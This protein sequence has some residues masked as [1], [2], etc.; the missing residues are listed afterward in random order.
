MADATPSQK[1]TPETRTLTATCHCKRSSLSF[2]VPISALPI[3]THFCHCGI[4]RHVQGVV[5]TVHAPIPEPS[6]KDESTFAK[7]HSSAALE[8]WFCSTC[9]A[10]MV[11]CLEGGKQWLVAAAMV[12]AEE[13]VWDIH[14]HI[15]V[16]D[17]PRGVAPFLK[18]IG[19]KELEMLKQ[20]EGSGTFE[21]GKDDVGKKADGT[22]ENT[23]LRAR[24]QCGGVDFSI[25]P[26]RSPSVFDSFDQS[27]L[28]KDKSKWYAL[29]DLCDTCRLTSGH[30]IASWMFPVKSH[31]ELADGSPYPEDHVFG[32]IKTYK[33][34]EN[35]LRTFCGTCGATVAYYCPSEKGR[36]D[37]VDIAVG[38]LEGDDLRREDVLEWRTKRAAWAE[39]CKWPSLKEALE[40]GLK[41]TA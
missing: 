30:P 22:D 32:T 29:Y 39:D 34:S 16:E 9:G 17:A 2:T 4:C 27:I 19:G 12:D 36:T 13:S 18:S 26:P 24:C 33:S 7:F 40:A 20:G 3:R 1:T 14:Q 38:L 5:A 21:F 8:R 10:D 28:P 35:V 15:Y 11:D 37:I 23:K 41:R 25:F 6:I 31:I